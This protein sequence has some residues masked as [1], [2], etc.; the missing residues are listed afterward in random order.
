PAEAFELLTRAC[1]RREDA[2]GCL[3]QLFGAAR[4][5]GDD[6]VDEVGR[7]LVAA[8]GPAPSCLKIHERLARVYQA[9]G[10]ERAALASWERAALLSEQSGHWRR[11]FELALRLP[12][13][14]AARRALA[15]L[16]R[17]AG[18][19]LHEERLR[20]NRLFVGAPP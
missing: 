14:Q 20:L 19:P 18:A 1:P 4:L 7:L 11:V 8:C 12:E 6:R 16:E 5:L 10:Q 9:S 15:A 17:A 2:L 3:W 13:P